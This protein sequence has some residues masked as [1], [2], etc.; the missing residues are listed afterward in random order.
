MCK[1]AYTLKSCRAHRCVKKM[2][3]HWAYIVFVSSDE[4][5]P[6][7]KG[8]IVQTHGPYSKLYAKMDTF[9]PRNCRFRSSGGIILDYHL[10]IRVCSNHTFI[11]RYR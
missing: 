2:V 6:C 3:T 11:Y 4:K 9:G 8:G 1:H 5:P 7:T 10:T